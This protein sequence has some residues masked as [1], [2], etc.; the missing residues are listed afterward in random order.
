MLIES[1]NSYHKL[2]FGWIDKIPHERIVIVVEVVRIESVVYEVF[3]KISSKL[4]HRIEFFDI[5][6]RDL[7]IL[8]LIFRQRQ[9][10]TMQSDNLFGL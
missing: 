10:N 5:L 7:S 9:R 6:K 8:L 3:V 2:I 4:L 1:E